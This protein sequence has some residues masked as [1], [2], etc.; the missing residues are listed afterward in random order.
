MT[1]LLFS[2]WMIV[3]LMGCSSKIQYPEGILK[4]SEM[5]SVLWDL[6]RADALT[7][8]LRRRDTTLKPVA[9]NIDLYTNIFNIHH[10]SKDIFQSSYYFYQSKPD[11]LR[12][13]VDS[14]NVIQQRKLINKYSQP[15]M[16]TDSG[17]K[18]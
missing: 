18:S 4:P 11:L 15:K 12:S 17:A 7:S 14:I 3:N 16:P 9:K 8:E 6:I 2:A 5:Q 10:I 1:K 13:I